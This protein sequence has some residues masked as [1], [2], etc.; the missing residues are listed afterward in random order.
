MADVNELELTSGNWQKYSRIS[1]A[2][3]VAKSDVSDEFGTDWSDPARRCVLGSR[4]DHARSAS[5]PSAPQARK[6]LV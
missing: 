3:R 1:R 5:G 2:E 6:V 4:S